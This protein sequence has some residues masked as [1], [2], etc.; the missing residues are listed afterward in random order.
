MNSR[1]ETGVRT[2]SGRQKT[3]SNRGWRTVA[4]A[5]VIPVAALL[6]WQLVVQLRWVSDDFLP[7]PL[8]IIGSFAELIFSG[9]FYTDM[10]VSFNRVLIGFALGGS[11]GL[12]FGV[13]VGMFRKVEQA[14]DPTVQMIRMIPHLAIAPLI[15]LWFGFTETSKILI[16]AK[17]TFFPLYINT[18]LG[19]RSADRQLFEVARA[20]EFSRFQQAVRLVLP[21]ALPNILLGVRVAFGLAW[22]CV[23]IAELIG[24]NSGLGFIIL[25]AQQISD[26]PGLFAGVAVFALIGVITDALV[27][28]L[29]RT[30]LRWRD[31]YKG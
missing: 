29:E 6:L 18:Y 11:L 1:A 13:A 22:I 5:A 21:S 28:L 4:Q 2:V 15:I 9:G 25:H 23:L 17:G 31:S 8:T 27:Q 24:S 3:G 7:S 19:I 12:A 10:R 16:I 26:A 20:L 30:L 14:V